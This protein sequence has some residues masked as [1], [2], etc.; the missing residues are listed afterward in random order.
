M[1]IKKVKECLPVGAQILVEM[2][3]EQEILGTTISITS[4]GRKSSLQAYVVAV[5]PGLAT[6]YQDVKVKTGDRVLL[7]AMGMPVPNFGTDSKERAL[8]DPHIIKA[9]LVE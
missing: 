9:I 2:L 3:T 4:T 6:A 1:K 5:G 8:V 7:S